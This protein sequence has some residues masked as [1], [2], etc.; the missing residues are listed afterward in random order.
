MIA[1]EIKKIFK[2]TWLNFKNREENEIP[3]YTNFELYEI[4][5]YNLL[6]RYLDKLKEFKYYK[7]QR[8]DF[9]HQIGNLSFNITIRKLY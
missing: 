6:K 9:V 1:T 4:G 3:S 8:T 7:L 5:Y 2:E